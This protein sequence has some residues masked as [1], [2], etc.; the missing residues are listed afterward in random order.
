MAIIARNIPVSVEFKANAE[1]MKRIVDNFTEQFS[2]V[3]PGTALGKS[4]TKNLPTKLLCV[5]I[6][7]NI[8]KI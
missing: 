2:H 1:S 6:I 4:F 8:K 5:I 3:D 7:L